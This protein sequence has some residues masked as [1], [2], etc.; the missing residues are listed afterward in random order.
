MLKCWV[1]CFCGCGCTLFHR[2]ERLKYGALRLDT[3][4]VNGQGHLCL[5]GMSLR[6]C[7]QPC[8]WPSPKLHHRSY[9]AAEEVSALRFLTNYTLH[10]WRKWSRLLAG[11]VFLV[12][13]GGKLFRDW[14]KHSWKQSDTCLIFSSVTKREHSGLA[15]TT[16]RAEKVL[17]IYQGT[18]KINCIPT[19]KMCNFFVMYRSRQCSE[20]RGTLLDVAAKTWLRHQLNFFLWCVIFFFSQ[21]SYLCD[22]DFLFQGYIYASLNTIIRSAVGWL[23]PHSRCILCLK[24]DSPLTKKR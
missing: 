11:S 6:V 2:S 5:C 7:V 21:S 10:L 19:G 24:W 13:W 16:K 3:V 20:E 22:Y 14:K 12:R 23:S 8:L 15:V 17:N 4:G 9:S 1:V 18:N